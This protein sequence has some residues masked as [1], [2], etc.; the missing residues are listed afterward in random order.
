MN[1]DQM[2]SLL[3]QTQLQNTILNRETGFF[4]S[5]AYDWNLCPGKH[6]ITQ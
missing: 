3:R 6:I 2:I 1:L 5:A 4:S